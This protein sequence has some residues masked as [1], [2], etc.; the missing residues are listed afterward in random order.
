MSVSWTLHTHKTD[1]IEPNQF[2]NNGEDWT[3]RVGISTSDEQILDCLHG[4]ESEDGVPKS[5]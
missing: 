1:I 5:M 2:A 3:V 4:V